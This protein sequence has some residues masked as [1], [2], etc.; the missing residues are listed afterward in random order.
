MADVVADVVGLLKR[1]LRRL[2]HPLLPAVVAALCSQ[3]LLL[4]PLLQHLPHRPTPDQAAAVD[5]TPELLRLGRRLTPAMTA[6]VNLGQPI[7]LPL[8]PPPP[9]SLG[10]PTLGSPPGRQP[11]QP[12]APIRRRPSRTD[13]VARPAAT[14][15]SP[16]ISPAAAVANLPAT[17][18]AA[19][20]LARTLAEA[21]RTSI[22]GEGISPAMAALQRRQWWLDPAQA[23]QLQRAWEEADASPQPPE[24]SDLPD[25]V[26]LK[27][28]D[29]GTLGQLGSGDAR[30]R[31]L[32]TRQHLTLIW[33]QGPQLWLLKLP[34]GENQ[35]GL[36][37][38]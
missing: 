8:P 27:R 32:V 37:N 16:P 1:Q 17:P 34:L 29:R 20:E 24:W 21:A 11:Q 35:Q 18:A 15:P 4:L 12:P 5:D 10:S 28:V 22:P 6:A 36:T 9:P 19:L 3:G 33:D 2:R 26:Q 31:S 23:R 25:G 14:R 30:G 7:S 38:S 13:P